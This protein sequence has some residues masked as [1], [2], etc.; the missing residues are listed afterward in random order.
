MQ[1]IIKIL[2]LLCILLHVS[3]R[4]LRIDH[5]IVLISE[6]DLRS[7]VQKSFLKCCYQGMLALYHRISIKTSCEVVHSL[8]T[9]GL[10]A[11]LMWDQRCIWNPFPVALSGFVTV[12]FGDYVPAYNYIRMWIIEILCIDQNIMF[13]FLTLTD[14][15]VDKR[16]KFG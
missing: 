10:S 9:A 13:N 2:N 8:N 4:K 5:I 1:L 14:K 6:T 11:E 12:M 3:N 15:L 7:N 16:R